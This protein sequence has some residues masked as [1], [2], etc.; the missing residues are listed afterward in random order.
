MACIAPHI[1]TARG[2]WRETPSS[3]SVDEQGVLSAARLRD[4]T[5]MFPKII[6]PRKGATRDGLRKYPR[7]SMSRQAFHSTH[8][9]IGYAWLNALTRGDGDR[10]YASVLVSAYL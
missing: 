10:R 4:N 6:F 8:V 1:E 9:E 7:L 2:P 5:G 3:S